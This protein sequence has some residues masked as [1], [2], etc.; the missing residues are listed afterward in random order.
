MRFL[1]S[2]TTRASSRNEEHSN[3][4]RSDPLGTGS[5]GGRSLPFKLLLFDQIR[6]K[7]F[8]IGLLFPFLFHPQG[9]M[10]SFSKGL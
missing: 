4:R 10:F 6:T 2:K 3:L 8:W 1:N 9:H 5:G 7:P